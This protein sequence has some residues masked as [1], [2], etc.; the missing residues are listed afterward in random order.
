[1]RC[2]SCVSDSGEDLVSK[3][4]ERSGRNRRTSATQ[5]PP[6]TRS[7]V[8]AINRAQPPYPGSSS[9][10][11]RIETGATCLRIPRPAWRPIWIQATVAAAA[12]SAVSTLP[13]HRLHLPTGNCSRSVSGPWRII[14]TKSSRSP[15]S[16]DTVSD[17]ARG[18]MADRM[19]ISTVSWDQNLVI[20]SSMTSPITCMTTVCN[21]AII[22]W[23]LTS[24]ESW[25]PRQVS[26]INIRPRTRLHR[27][28]GKWRVKKVLERRIVNNRRMY[29]GLEFQ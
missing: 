23:R 18:K 8:T 9:S 1:M 14:S 13:V 22:F 29:L 3:T 6:N 15:Y 27:A 17:P 10:S 24:L 2:I 16:P 7:E 20:Y 26:P 12:G 25:K 28:G 19:T 21:L 4:V 11:S 5:R